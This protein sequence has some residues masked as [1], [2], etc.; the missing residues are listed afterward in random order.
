MFLG[1]FDEDTETNICVCLPKIK[2]Y[3]WVLKWETKDILRY[4]TKSKLQDKVTT[5]F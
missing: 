2:I 1:S 4:V 5:N 3:F